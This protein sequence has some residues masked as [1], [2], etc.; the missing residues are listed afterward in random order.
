MVR[1]IIPVTG[2]SISGN[3]NELQNE[4]FL[5]KELQKDNKFEGPKVIKL[6]N[7]TVAGI[8]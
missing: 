5:S 8:E 7:V 2:G 1:N 3:I 4:L 6:L